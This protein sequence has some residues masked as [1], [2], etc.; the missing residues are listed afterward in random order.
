MSEIGRGLE[1]R[2]SGSGS[3]RC[4]C[5]SVFAVHPK[6]LTRRSRFRCPF[7]ASGYLRPMQ[8]EMF[9]Y[10]SNPQSA[11]FLHLIFFRYFVLFRKRLQNGNRAAISET[12]WS[13]CGVAHRYYQTARLIPK[14]TPMKHITW[15]NTTTEYMHELAQKRAKR[16]LCAPLSRRAA[17]AFP[18]IFSLHRG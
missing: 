7:P 2:P 14:Y 4:A 16:S 3:H 17:L 1:D 15:K 9:S 6:R 18:M 5:Y 12:P 13:D 8:P 11:R 10:A